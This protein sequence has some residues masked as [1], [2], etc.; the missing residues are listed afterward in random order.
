MLNFLFFLLL[1]VNMRFYRQSRVF[2]V[3]NVFFLKF[4]VI[5]VV[6]NLLK[7]VGLYGQFVSGIVN[8]SALPVLGSGLITSYQNALQAV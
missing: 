7:T 1:P 8:K 6:D 4:S 2:V 5:L 3:K